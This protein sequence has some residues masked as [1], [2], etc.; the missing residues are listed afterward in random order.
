[1]RAGEEA[2]SHMTSSTQ[3][4]ESNS[5]TAREISSLLK[6]DGDASPIHGDLSERARVFLIISLI[7]ISRGCPEMAPPATLRQPLRKKSKLRAD[8]SICAITELTR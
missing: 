5:N 2:E 6:S 4:R 8:C 1:M 3:Q 7:Y